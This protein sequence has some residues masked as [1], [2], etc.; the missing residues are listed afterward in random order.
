MASQKKLMIFSDWFTPAYKAGGPIKSVQ[1]LVNLI[2]QEFEVKVVTSNTDE[3]DQIPLETVA[4]DQWV[5]KEGYSVIYLSEKK[6]SL[7]NIALLIDQERP[8]ICYFN[9]LFSLKFTLIPL[10]LLKNNKHINPRIVLAPRGM[11]G[12][13]A[14]AIKKNKKQLF[15]KASR[16]FKLF[17]GIRWHA[18]ANTERDEIQ[19][20]FGHDTD[21]SV[22]ANIPNDDF[23]NHAPEKNPGQLNLVFI[24]RISPKKNLKFAITCLSELN[25]E[26]SVQMEIYGPLEDEFY[27]NECQKEMAKLPD[28][29]KVEYKGVVTPKDLYKVWQ[30]NHFLFFPTLHE[31]YGHVIYESLSA[32]IP[33][34][35]SDQTPWRDLQN[36]KLGFD[37]PLN[38][39]KGWIQSLQ[40]AANFTNDEFKDYSA[41][42]VQFA[43]SKFDKESFRKR[44]IQLFQA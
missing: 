39:K 1:N 17:D 13:G 5:E 38:D 23:Q 29:I 44:Y 34:I 37:L 20:H 30:N 12:E 31:N 3:G 10:F 21:I 41:S 15:L 42:C 18:T 4:F 14:L 24:S 27:W 33:L 43:I 22:E 6:R 9:S 36:K 16:L 35:I 19:L 8:D 11:L 25:L 32:G 40:H 28:N 26:G 2:H 7:R